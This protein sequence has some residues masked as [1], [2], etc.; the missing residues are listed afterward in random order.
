MQRTKLTKQFRVSS[1]IK[2][3]K[4]PKCPIT[5]NHIDLLSPNMQIIMQNGF[6]RE[7]LETELNIYFKQNQEVCN[8]C[9]NNVQIQYKT[10]PNIFIEIDLMGYY[11]QENCTLSSIPTNLTINGCK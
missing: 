4:C 3:I 5:N 10:Q 6:T 1:I 8:I 9:T 2:T 7:S 11:G